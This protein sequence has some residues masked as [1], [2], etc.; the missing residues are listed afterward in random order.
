[1]LCFG[2]VYLHRECRLCKGRSMCTCTVMRITSWVEV[3]RAH[4]V[5]KGCWQV[6]GTTGNGVLGQY[7][8]SSW[9]VTWFTYRG[10]RAIVDMPWLSVIFALYKL[11][12]IFLQT[13]LKCLNY[14]CANVIILSIFYSIVKQRHSKYLVFAKFKL[15]I[16]H[17][18]AVQDCASMCFSHH[19]T[20]FN[21]MIWKGIGSMSGMWTKERHTACRF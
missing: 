1:M 7:L 20:N 10:W 17:E 13:H 6:G 3:W 9:G 8:V 5:H 14:K 4:M 11:Q 19:W 18:E 16:K 2:P 21:S 15:N 12:T